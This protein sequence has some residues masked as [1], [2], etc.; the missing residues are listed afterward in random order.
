MNSPDRALGGEL[1]LFAYALLG[2]WRRPVEGATRFSHQRELGRGSLVAGML[3]VLLVEMGA[4]HAALVRT[5]P[6]VAWTLTIA[7]AWAALWLLGDYQA[8]RLRRSEFT[9]GVLRLRVGLRACADVPLADIVVARAGRL[10]GLP[11]GRG[12]LRAYP[13]PA[14]ATVLLELATPVVARGLYGRQRPVRGI[15]LAPDDRARFVAALAAA[16][17]AVETR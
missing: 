11:H 14:E 10:G 9:G 17:V 8:L 12:L 16:G 15:A 3:L 7:S 4:V 2:P 6:H 5:H 13:K 1:S